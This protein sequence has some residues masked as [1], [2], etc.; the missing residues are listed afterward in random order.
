MKCLLD[1]SAKRLVDEVASLHFCGPGGSLVSVMNRRK[2]LCS[3]VATAAVSA[4]PK[5]LKAD[6][7][8]SASARLTIEMNQPGQAIPEN[9]LGLS[10]ETAQ[11]S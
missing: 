4:F 2:F 6:S 7:I 8:A 3:T 10:Y 9:F 5:I 1:D 11:L